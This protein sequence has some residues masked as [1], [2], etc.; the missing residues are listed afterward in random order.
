MLVGAILFFIG[1]GFASVGA[2]VG[3]SMADDWR[4]YAI[5]CVVGGII[6][7]GLFLLMLAG[8]VV[9]SELIIG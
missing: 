7:V 2:W 8:A 9:F 6:G 5:G 3:L 1:V 4:G